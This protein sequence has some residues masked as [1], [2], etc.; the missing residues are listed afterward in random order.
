MNTPPL[1]GDADAPAHADLVRC[2]EDK[3]KAGWELTRNTP[4]WAINYRPVKRAQRPSD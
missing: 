4:S 2:L 1:S 3:R